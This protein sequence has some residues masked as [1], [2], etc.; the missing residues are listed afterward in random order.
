MYDFLDKIISKEFDKLHVMSDE[1]KLKR[2]SVSPR[3]NDLS[4]S[5]S[6]SFNVLL[7]KIHRRLIE[8]QNSTVGTKSLS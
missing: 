3:F 8:S 6:D 1:Y 5:R 7:I 4:K 2:I